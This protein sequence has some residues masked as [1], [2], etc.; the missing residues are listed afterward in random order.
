MLFSSLFQYLRAH[1]LSSESELSVL[2]VV[3]RAIECANEK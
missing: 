3:A 1:S 2:R